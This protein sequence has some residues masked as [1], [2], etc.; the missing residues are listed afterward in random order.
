MRATW[1]AA[2][3]NTIGKR[4]ACGDG[5]G[6]CLD[7]FECLA[8]DLSP[9]PRLPR[10]PL[11]RR[12]YRAH[13]RRPSPPHRDAASPSSPPLTLPPSPRRHRHLP[14]CLRFCPFKFGESGG[15]AAQVA[16][17]CAGYH[18]QCSGCSVCNGGV[19]QSQHPATTAFTAPKPR[20]PPSREREGGVTPS[21]S[22]AARP[23]TDP[24]NQRSAP[25]PSFMD[26]QPD[27]CHRLRRRGQSQAPRHNLVCRRPHLHRPA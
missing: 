3:V 22:K 27:R 21:P 11:R 16:K 7:C 19:K 25:Q 14:A 5:G 26:I 8:P 6:V 1:C 23:T 18:G 12:H 13:H 2:R 20:E 10:R 17:V 15:G 24:P 4:A 9:P